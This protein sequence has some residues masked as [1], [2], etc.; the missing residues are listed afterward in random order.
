MFRPEVSF[1]LGEQKKAG[2]SGIVS[3]DN[4]F[5]V[6][7]IGSGIDEEKGHKVLEFIKDFLKKSRIENLSSFDDFIASVIKENNLP[8]G[9]S[10]SSGFLKDD[11]IYL[12]TAGEAKIYIRRQGKLGLLI[13]GEATASGPVEDNDFFI[14]LTEN[15][16]NLVAG[17]EGLDK[18]FDHRSPGEIIEEI[19]PTLKGKNDAGAAALFVDFHKEVEDDALFY[20]ETTEE[21]AAMGE[22]LKIYWLLMKNSKKTLTFITVMILFLVLVWSVILGYQRRTST[23]A[24]NKIKLT[25]ELVSQKL[26]TAEEVAFLNMDRALVLIKESKEEVKKLKKE[27]G[28]KR[29]EVGE[30]ENKISQTEGKILRKEQRKYSEFFDLTVDNK[31]ATGKRIYLDENTTYIL[32]NKRGVIYKFSLDKKSLSKELFPEIK[33]ASLAA[34]YEDKVFLFVKGSGVYIIDTDKPKKVIEN[35]KDWGEIIDMYIYNGNIYLLDKGKDEIWKYLSGGDTYG[36]K[37]SYFESAQAID[38]SM[39]IS[40]SIDGS[41]YLAGDSIIVKYTSGL[42]DGFSIDLPVDKTNFNK[43]FTSSESEKIYLWDKSKGTVYVI[44]KTGE[45]LEQI[46]SDILSRAS[47]LVVYKDSVYVLMGSKIFKIE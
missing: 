21:K 1:Y 22:T 26:S 12:K 14:F 5:F 25:Q 27:I 37:D 13:E 19:T 44:G 4:L 24:K 42:R 18:V 41:V 43:I 45:Y 38:L 34:G 47:D 16:L 28:D 30:L 46:N 3:Q 17:R 11:I 35:D 8:A 2:Y 32:D 31:E 23:V 20:R 6:V 39:I 40:F 7:E 33:S 9:F 10:I 15:F 29:K 36:S